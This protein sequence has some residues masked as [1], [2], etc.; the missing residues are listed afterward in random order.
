MET[1]ERLHMHLRVTP[2]QCSA[3]GWF[4][5]VIG[6]AHKDQFQSTSDSAPRWL[7]YSH[8]D[9]QSQQLPVLQ[10]LAM[11]SDFRHFLE[12]RDVTPENT[13]NVEELKL[14]VLAFIDRRIRRISCFPRVAAAQRLTGKL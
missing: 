5:D 14:L 13:G 6:R 11:R 8:P 2:V 1:E 9:P 3:F 4:W 7:G 12:G 10:S